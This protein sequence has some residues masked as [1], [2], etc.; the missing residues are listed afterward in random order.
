MQTPGADEPGSAVLL[1][2]YFAESDDRFV[3][4]LLTVRDPSRLAALADR[5]KVDPRPWARRMLFAYLD[6]EWR[7]PGH[8]VLVKR[9]YKQ[10]E[11]QADLELVCA[12]AHRFDLMIRRQLEVRWQWDP[13]TRQGI[14]GSE[15]VVPRNGLPGW[16]PRKSSWRPPSPGGTVLFSAHTRYYLRRRVARV[17]RQLSFRDHDAY[18]QAASW[19][20]RRYRD[21]DLAEGANILDSRTLLDVCYRRS[22][23]LEFGYDH[24]DVREGASLQELEPAPRRIE[25]WQGQAAAETLWQ[26]SVHAPSRL[27]RKWAIAMLRAEHPSY[28]GQLSAEQVRTLLTSDDD[29]LEQLGG[30]LI[31]ERVDLGGWQLSDWLTLLHDASLSAQQVA[32][33]LILQHVQPERFSIEQVLSLCCEQSAPAASLGL[34]LLQAREELPSSL[35]QLEQLSGLRCAAVAEAVTARALEVL[36]EA[37]HYDVDRLT[38]FFDAPMAGVRS[39]AWMWLEREREQ[40]PA[41]RDPVLWCRLIETPHEPERLRLVRLL[42]RRGQLPGLS[43]DDL[44]PLWS[45]VLLGIHRGGR[46]KIVAL[47]QLGRVASAS[48]ECIEALLPVFAVAV[49]SVRPPEARIGLAALVGAVERLPSLREPVLATFPELRFLSDGAT[50]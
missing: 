38:R 9:L 22:P 28:L 16:P 46:H 25:N 42:A 35:D 34:K 37:Q 36:G 6:A 3:E 30:E 31:R 21:A 47:H 15:L 11:R 45:S 32:C 48:P 23:V 44:V 41:D 20:L 33:E 4:L 43:V 26:L 29:E 14:T 49:R 39:A 10:A 24:V 2:E 1:D 17:L 13:A 40:H 5:W 18:L 7:T 8:N 27:V 12:F 19:L 50:A